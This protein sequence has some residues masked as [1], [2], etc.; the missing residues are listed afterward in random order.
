MPR[1]S[2][3][4]GMGS[5]R[6]GGRGHGARP[7]VLA[8]VVNLLAS[9]ASATEIDLTWDA[10]VPASGYE[11]EQSLD[12]VTWGAPAAVIP[13]AYAVTGLD[14]ATQYFFRVRS[15]ASGDPGTWSATATAT[16]PAAGGFALT[17]LV[18]GWALTA[19][20]Q[21]TMSSS[22]VVA[23]GAFDL[24]P[25]AD[26]RYAAPS[27]DAAG[28]TS[29]GA[30]NLFGSLLEV[31]EVAPLVFAGAQPILISY[32]VL[33]A[34]EYTIDTDHFKPKAT[35]ADDGS[36]AFGADLAAI[37]TDQSAFEGVATADTNDYIFAT[38]SASIIVPGTARVALIWWD[39]S[40][41]SAQT[42]AGAPT[43][44][45]FAGPVF[46][47]SPLPKLQ[48][49]VSANATMRHLRIWRGANAATLAADATFRSWLANS[50]AGRTDAELAAYTP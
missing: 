28:V 6:P 46:T 48:V 47:D 38:D 33:T 1:L 25:T 17:D 11:V 7:P 42:D 40:Q 32:R 44:T 24:A 19:G 31:Q 10:Q 50:G 9:A 39:G 18:A 8:Q 4:V 36:V 29:T 3:S 37:D 15:T 5:S 13:N 21:Q 34:A 14:A 22:G 45:A 23:S 27:Y 20:P 41:L 35:V 43:S 12:G 26:V 49:S 16:T 2:L 30:A